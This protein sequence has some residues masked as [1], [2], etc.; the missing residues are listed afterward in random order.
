MYSDAFQ[1]LVDTGALYQFRTGPS[2]E[3]RMF[4]P[5]AYLCPPIIPSRADFDF[6]RFGGVVRSP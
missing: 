6:E 1:H 4:N 2:M 5:V 3:F